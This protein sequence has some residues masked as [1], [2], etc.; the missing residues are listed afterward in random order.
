MIIATNWFSVILSDS[1]VYGRIACRVRVSQCDSHTVW[2][3]HCVRSVCSQWWPS[4]SME[5]LQRGLSRQSKAVNVA[6]SIQFVTCSLNRFICWNFI[7]PL[8]RNPHCGLD[9]L[10]AD[11]SSAPPGDLMVNSDGK[12]ISAVKD[13]NSPLK[14]QVPL[15]MFRNFRWRESFE[16]MKTIAWPTTELTLIEIVLIGLINLLIGHHNGLPILSNLRVSTYQPLTWWHSRNLQVK[17]FH[18]KQIAL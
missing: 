17:I 7:Q 16:E 8:V 15:V 1:A 10:V 6:F 5:V 18:L 13:E 3:T 14:S 2:L 9:D 12:E 11:S 4:T